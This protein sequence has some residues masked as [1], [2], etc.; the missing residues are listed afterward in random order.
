MLVAELQNQDPTDP[1]DPM[2]YTSQLASFSA[3]A[4][5]TETNGTLNA[6]LAAQTSGFIGQTLTSGTTT[7]TVQS[8][9]TNGT[10]A[11]TAT[12]TNGGTID[13]TSGVI[14]GSPTSSSTST[15]S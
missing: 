10:G 4:Q 3:V 11:A 2:Q 1:T 13:L 15:S 6:L 9:T 12:L 7:G 8:V 5:Q 14:L